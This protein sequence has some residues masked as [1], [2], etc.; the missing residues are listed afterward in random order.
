MRFLFAPIAVVAMLAL[1]SC[2]AHPTAEPATVATASILQSSDPPPGS[3]VA[4]PVNALVLRF[5]PAARLDEVMVT[6]PDGVMPMMITAAG[7]Q[8]R[9][10]VPLPG[11]GTGSYTVAWRATAGA[12]AHS[13]SFAFTVK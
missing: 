5:N 3:T 11:L 7:E 10:S 1:S 12:R 8:A 4:R 6:G 2:A 9:Y 13:G